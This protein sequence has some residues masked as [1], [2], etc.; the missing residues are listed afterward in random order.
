MVVQVI[1]THVNT[2]FDGLGAMLAAG[3][4]YPE[5]ALYFPGHL[6]RLVREFYSSHKDLLPIKA[7]EM[8][9]LGTVS[10]LIIVDT[11]QANRLGH[12]KALVQRPD[13]KVTI[14]DH[15]PTP[16]ETIAGATVQRAEVGAITSFLVNQLAAEDLRPSE[17]EATAM[18]LGIYSETSSLTGLN[19]TVEDVAAIRFLFAAGANLEII[20]RYMN[21]PLSHDQRA[22]LEEMLANSE[23]IYHHGISVLITICSIDHY[24]NG[25]GM[26]AER[27][28]AIKDVD[29]IFCLVEMDGRVHL[30]ARSRLNHLPVDEIVA[31]FG[32]AGHPLAAAATIRGRSLLDLKDQLLSYLESCLKPPYTAADIMS[33]PVHSTQPD[34]LLGEV[35]QA[36]LRYGHNGLPVLADGKLVGVISRRDV[37]KA[38]HHGLEHAPVKGFMS[39]EVVAVPPAASLD[40]MQ[41]LL[42]GRDI[43][44]LP[45]VDGEGQVLGIVTR[46][47]V[48]RSLHG[49]SYPHWYQ[50]NVRS[51]ADNE[52]PETRA[53]ADMMTDRLPKR[54]QGLFL[55]IGQEASRHQ[56]SAYL[57]GG[58]VRD[59]L[60][61]V[62]NSD[63]DIVVEPS[64]LEFAE[65]LGRVFGGSVQTHPQF[66]TATITRPDGVSIDLV[67]ARSE[68]YISPAAMPHVEQ[69]NLKQD[70]YRRDFTINTMAIALHGS[71]YGQFYDF[72]GGRADLEAGIVRVLYNLSF[73]ED[74]TR[75]LRAIRFEQRYGFRIEPE[76]M[77]FLQNSLEHNLLEKVSPERIKLE[78][79]HILREPKAA[80]MI[81]RAH[82]LAVWAA[83]LPGLELTDELIRHLRDT[84]DHIQWFEKLQT[85]IT[86]E[87]WLVYLL[88]LSTGVRE[89]LLQQWCTR[90]ALTKR[91]CELLLSF[92][93]CSASLSTSLVGATDNQEVFR[94]LSG[95]PAE[96]QVAVAVLLGE[97][98]TS[99]LAD[100]WGR[101]VGLQIEVD[102][103]DILGLGL[104]PG[105][106]VGKVLRQIHMARLN[107]Q[108]ATKEQELALAHQLLLP[109]EG[110]R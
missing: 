60:L 67:T 31:H 71:Q 6:S 4:L 76:T 35:G 19:T 45:V 30:S 18:A 107:G 34:V 98:I 87:R 47:D 108:V 92:A 28:A 100:Y 80:H 104:K 65:Q 42:I 9:S 24:L 48:L 49:R 38:I 81:L 103:Y 78:I 69:S 5:A 89:E 12:F 101:M 86:I 17:L 10:E 64:A 11:Q 23:M 14:Y 66:G 70:L 51:Y 32:G 94:L 36:M 72:F 59:L 26:L 62:P 102:G 13:L 96:C 83:I 25:L 90:L 29:L 39:S 41:R 91:E 52:P 37:D 61:G 73:V 99:Q 16:S 63:I 77:R 58:I 84:E 1:T 2:N 109:P 110:G 15:H 56:V 106:E 43:G 7:P 20:H 85:D 21:A 82:E 46:T 57:V 93:P 50:M 33:Q 54:L 74:P 40:E 68:F 75:I 3:M 55:L 22:L 27:L 88:L 8:L 53:L 105:P 97:A 79:K 95:Q 44:R